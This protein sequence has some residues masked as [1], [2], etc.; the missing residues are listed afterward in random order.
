MTNM[1]KKTFVIEYN[2]VGVHFYGWIIVDLIEF[3]LKK[4]IN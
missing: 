3:T 4:Y 1:L 2:T